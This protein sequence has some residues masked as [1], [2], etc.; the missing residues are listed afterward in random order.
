[1]TVRRSGLVYE[2]LRTDRSINGLSEKEILQRISE[3]HDIF[4][5]KVLRKQ[6]SVALRRGIDFGIIKKRFNKYK[7]E[8]G[9]LVNVSW[10]NQTSK[11]KRS[12]SKR[13][14]GGQTKKGSAKFRKVST[15]RKRQTRKGRV[16][17]PKPKL[18]ARQPWTQEK[19]D[20]RKETIPRL[21][22]HR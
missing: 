14:K 21:V 13:K 22:K 11:R 9:F 19:R 15:N 18:P 1:M 7:F 17:V 4:A 10:K 3:R 6:I 2:L 8:P 12:R 5:G 16:I 20:L